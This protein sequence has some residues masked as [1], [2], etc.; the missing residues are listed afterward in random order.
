MNVRRTPKRILN[1]HPSDQRPQI[2]IDLRPASQ[3]ARF[4]A[5]I[6]AKAGTMP[7]HKGLGPDDRHGRED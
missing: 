4:P 1:G 2:R 7:A 5:P 6:A 3:G